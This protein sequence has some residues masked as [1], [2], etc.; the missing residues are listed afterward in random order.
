MAEQRWTPASTK[1]SVYIGKQAALFEKAACNLFIRRDVKHL[2]SHGGPR[3]INGR[4]GDGAQH[5]HR[6]A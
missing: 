3:F 4:G 6:P 2:L 1:L 5:A